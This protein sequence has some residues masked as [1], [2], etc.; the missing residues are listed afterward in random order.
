[1]AL[2]SKAIAVEVTQTKSIDHSYFS[3][4]GEQLLELISAQE[5]VE[6]LNIS[7]MQRITIDILRQLI[8]LLPNLRRL[9]LLHTIPDADILTLL[10]ESP[11]LFYRID[12]IIHFAFLHHLGKAVFPLEFSHIFN[13]ETGDVMITSVPYFTPDQDAQALTDYL[14][15]LKSEDH[16]TILTTMRNE[17]PLLARQHMR[18]Q[19][20]SQPEDVPGPRG[21][22]H[23]FLERHSIS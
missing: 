20:A 8:P 19:Y 4:T 15:L 21:L 22:C 9:V 16:Y 23:L 12:S 10:S 17:L 1:M 5:G 14:S 3:A 7:H 2:L 13:K 11:E 6:V 18:L